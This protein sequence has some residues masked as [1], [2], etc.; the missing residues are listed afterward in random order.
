MV[1]RR[2]GDA[3][4]Q[5][6][7][8]GT[9]TTLCSARQRTNDR[10]RAEILEKTE[11]A[12]TEARRIGAERGTP[13]FWLRG[14]VNADELKK[15]DKFFNETV[16]IKIGDLGSTAAQAKAS[17]SD[18][19]GGD[20]RIPAVARRC[21]AGAFAFTLKQ[22]GESI[23]FENCAGEAHPVPKRQTVP[24]AEV[25]G[26]EIVASA[27]GKSYKHKPAGP[28]SDKIYEAPTNHTDAMYVV[29]GCAQIKNKEKPKIAEGKNADLWDELQPHI[30]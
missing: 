1:P 4:R 3:G 21:G 20:N 18:G 16:P 25:K 14:I 27:V 23:S 10:D 11:W 13:C 29:K 22:Q 8:F 19:A 17:Y 6:R 15:D 30:R 9:D 24:R 28:A 2:A 26:V 5:R 7:H 12:D